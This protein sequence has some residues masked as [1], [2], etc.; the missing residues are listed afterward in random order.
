[1]SYGEC[2]PQTALS[3]ATSLRAAAQQ[4]NSQGI[5]WFNASGDSGAADCASTSSSNGQLAVDLPA[6]I[7]EVTGVGGT[8]FVDTTGT[9]WALTNGPN[10]ESALSYIP[11]AAWNT[12]AT[13]G[14]P[15]ASGGGASIFFSKPSWQTGPGVPSDGARDVPDISMNASAD[16]DGYDAIMNG[17]TFSVGGTSAPTP[18]FAG[19]ATILNQYLVQNG[20]LSKPGLGNINPNLYSL[21]QSAP[22]AFHDVTTGDNIVTATG[23]GRRGTG[24]GTP[25]GYTAGPGYDQ[26]TGLGSIDIYNLFQ[27]WTGVATGKPT[28]QIVVSASAPT[29]TAGQTTV[30]TATVTSSN[31]TPPTGS[32]TFLLGATTLGSATLTGSGAVAT[33]T[34]TVSASQLATGANNIA[35]QYSSDNGAFNGTAGSVTVTVTQVVV[36]PSI[37]GVADGA[38][39]SHNYAP[40]EVLSIFG[41]GLAGAVQTASSVPLPVSMGGVSVTVSGV[42]APQYMVSPGQLNVQIPYQT[43][44]GSS[45][46]VVVRYNGLTASYSFNVSATAPAIFTDQ[47]SAPVPNGSGA[48]G[49]TITLFVTGVGAVSPALATGAA[50][51]SI[52]PVGNLPK[53]VNEPVSVTVGGINAAVQFAGIPAGL[54]GVMQINYTVPSGVPAGVQP[55]VVTVGSASSSEANLTVTH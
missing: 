10:S 2:E 26:V 12:S 29:V 24:T 33:A 51:S 38:S 3:Q 22:A 14:S 39:F 16:H 23:T 53:P 41:S 36:G 9:Y 1:M 48:P 31:G 25:V 28:P 47:T 7:P 37:A 17:K 34:L 6:S 20:S 21:A 4:A 45:A 49:S 19:I 54:V 42:T 44:V 35:V 13:D 43:A 5:T 15:S 55:V 32:V 40:G 30:L 50:P 18:I 46:T 8:Q 27:A 52:T 11:E